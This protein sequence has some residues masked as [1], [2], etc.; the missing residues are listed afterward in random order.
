MGEQRDAGTK[1]GRCSAVTKDGRPCA[2]LARPGR[3]TCPW[4]DAELAAERRAWARRGGAGRSSVARAR[5]EL[6][7]T[8]ADVAPIL[9]RT[10]VALE[11]GAMEPAR[12]SAM[13]AV[14]RSLVVVA[15]ASDL[16]QRVAELERQA[17]AVGRGGWSA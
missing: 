8:L 15:E 7:K 11:R 13:A 12:A 3:P 14:A 6:P 4:H 10:L 5:K 2:A 9:Y 1:P 16:E 17:A